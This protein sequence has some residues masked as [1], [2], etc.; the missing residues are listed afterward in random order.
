MSSRIVHLLIHVLSWLEEHSVAFG[1]RNDRDRRHSLK[2]PQQNPHSQSH[3]HAGFLILSERRDDLWPAYRDPL[4]LPVFIACYML[5]NLFTLLLSFWL[6]GESSSCI[7]KYLKVGFLVQVP[8]SWMSGCKTYSQY[9]RT[10]F[11]FYGNISAK[12]YDYCTISFFCDVSTIVLL[13]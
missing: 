13:S 4:W 12:K 6:G 1:V 10:M 11:Q 7:L 8:S 3:I 2:I 9:T 5:S